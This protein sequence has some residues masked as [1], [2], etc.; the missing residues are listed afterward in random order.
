MANLQELLLYL[1]KNIDQQKTTS[2]YLL[3]IFRIY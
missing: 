3:K 1:M 2:K